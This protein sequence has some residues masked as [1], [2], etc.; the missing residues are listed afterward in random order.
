MKQL[1]KS[2]GCHLAWMLVV[3][4]Y[5]FKLQ[6]KKKTWRF[7]VF[8]RLSRGKKVTM[9]KLKKKIRGNQYLFTGTKIECKW[10]LV[11]GEGGDV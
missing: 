3:N 8:E 2:C 7:Y 5:F 10:Y 9:E 1:S 11:F 4:L 6:K